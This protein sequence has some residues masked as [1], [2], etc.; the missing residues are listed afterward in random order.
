MISVKNVPLNARRRAYLEREAAS[1]RIARRVIT[2]SAAHA[3][4]LQA[5]H[6]ELRRP[7][8]VPHGLGKALPSN[9]YSA[10]LDQARF[11]V[12][13]T[14]D[15]RKGTDRVAAVAAAYAHTYGRLELRFVT[16]SPAETLREFG[17]AAENL[18]GVAIIHRSGLAPQ[19]LQREYLAATALLH[20]AR[21][22]SFGLPLIEAA[23]AGLPVVATRTGVAPDLLTG[24]LAALLV[25]GERPTDCARA[26]HET[27]IANDRW[28][29]AI[30]RN[31][32]RDFTRAAMVGGFL[33]AL[34][35]WSR[36]RR[37]EVE[38]IREV[39]PCVP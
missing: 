16:A 6:P 38:A 36:G 19:E 14:L 2:H 3:D 20:L 15:R 28:S 4:A 12:V 10:T 32:Q 26:M 23:A 8:I 33:Q 21:Y 24:E 13:G 9:R 35:N 39:Q 5:I 1:F 11:L 7:V 22:E 27:V 30:F 25:D 31:Y 34:E 18:H 29:A 17:F 37:A